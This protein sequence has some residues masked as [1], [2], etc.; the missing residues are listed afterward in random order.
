MI[1]LEFSLK[2]L[3]INDQRLSGILISSLTSVVCKGP[4]RAYKGLDELIRGYEGLQGRAFEGLLEDP[5]GLLR[6]W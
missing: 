4:I 5:E 1:Y 3:T 6:S 2:E